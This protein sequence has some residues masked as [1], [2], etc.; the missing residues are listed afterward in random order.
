MAAL[1]SSFCRGPFAGFE[2]RSSRTL[3]A[4]ARASPPRPRTI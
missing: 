3:T 4:F 1:Y 2:F